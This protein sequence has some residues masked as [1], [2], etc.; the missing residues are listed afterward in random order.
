MIEEETKTTDTTT[1]ENK[2]SAENKKVSPYDWAAFGFKVYQENGDMEKHIL[3]QS[4]LMKQILTN[5][6]QHGDGKMTE[7]VFSLYKSN[8]SVKEV[9][10]KMIVA[11]RS[12]W[13]YAGSVLNNIMKEYEEYYDKLIEKANLHG[14]DENKINEEK[15]AGLD[16]VKAKIEKLSFLSA[17]KLEGSSSLPQN[18]FYYFHPQAFIE[19]MQ[20]MPQ[21]ASIWPL[22]E[23]FGKGKRI[24]I[25]GFFRNDPP[26]KKHGAI[27][28]QH[29]PTGARG[30]A[31]GNVYSTHTGTVTLAEYSKT[32][33]NYVIIEKGNVRTQY[34]HL[35]SISD[36]IKKSINK[37]IE[38]KTILGKVGTTGR[39]EGNHLHYQI[40]VK[41]NG[42]WDKINPVVGNPTHIDQEG[43]DANKVFELK[44]VEQLA[45]EKK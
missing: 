19:Q 13:T 3:T 5:I 6:D 15:K 40:E 32:A 45:E 1:G 34:M 23:V 37:T 41:T 42:K 16:R 21:T 8:L 14:I 29:K 20:R 7:D 30:L 22:D 10:S 4:Q 35:D 18:C 44:N 31:G 9:M 26:T 17:V 24:I 12:E 36:V 2:S 38:A 27:D 25:S 43:A 11:H 28:I 33:G 39:S